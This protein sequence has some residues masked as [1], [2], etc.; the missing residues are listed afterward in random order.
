VLKNSESVQDTINELEMV[1]SRLVGKA[2]YD[3]IGVKNWQISQGIVATDIIWTNIDIFMQS[4]QKCQK[5]MATIGPIFISCFV[6]F[7]LLMVESLALNYLK[8]LSPVIMYITTTLG[9][10]YCFYATPW[11]TFKFLEKEKFYLKSAREQT[12]MHRLVLQLLFVVLIVPM[13][14]NYVLVRYSP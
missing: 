5:I 12:Y 11:L 13:F 2:H 10:V 3:K 4:S 7:G 9:V 6:V 1:K 14:F 8:F